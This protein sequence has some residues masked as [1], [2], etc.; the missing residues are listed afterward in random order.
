MNNLKEKVIKEIKKVYD[1]EIP[2][3]IYELGLIYNIKINKNNVVDIDMTLTSPNCPVAE[4]LPKQ[5]KEYILNVKGV[6]DV[7]LNLVWD[8]PWD[9]SKMSEAAK[10]ELNL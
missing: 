5:V 1:P 6:S 4:S 8:P 10:L 7:N 9:K 3:N 2:V